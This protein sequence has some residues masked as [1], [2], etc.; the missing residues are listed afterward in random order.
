MTG[1]LLPCGSC[2]LS[3]DLGVALFLTA[4]QVLTHLRETGTCGDELTDD[5]V[6]LQTNKVVDL[7][8]DG[9]FSQD[10]CAPPVQA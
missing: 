1:S 8:L 3:G 6:L 7:T 10:L 4:L 5:D 2:Q 9:G